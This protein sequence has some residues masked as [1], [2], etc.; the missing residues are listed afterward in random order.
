MLEYILFWLA[1]GIAE[2]LLAVVV[3]VIMLGIILMIERRK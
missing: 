2:V 3:I 1:R